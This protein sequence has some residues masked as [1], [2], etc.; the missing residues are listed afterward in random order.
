MKSA[1]AIQQGKLHTDLTSQ[2]F[3]ETVYEKRL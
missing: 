3:E 1:N 2:S